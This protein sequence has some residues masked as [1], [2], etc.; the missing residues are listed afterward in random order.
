MPSIHIMSQWEQ[1][2]LGLRSHPGPLQTMQSLRGRSVELRC[3]EFQGEFL[4]SLSF[5]FLDRVLW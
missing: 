1:H 2:R 3:F 5:G 4:R